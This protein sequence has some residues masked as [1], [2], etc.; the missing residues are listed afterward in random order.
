AAN[1]V[2]LVIH[3]HGGQHSQLR[4]RK[5]K[6]GRCTSDDAIAVIRSMAVRWS[7][8]DIAATLNRMGMRTSDLK[9][10]TVKRV[11]TARRKRGILGCRSVDPNGEWFTMSEA[12][13]HI[14]VTND[15][16][17]RLIKDG[18]LRAKQAVPNAPWRIQAC[19]L[20]SEAVTVELTRKHRPCGDNCKT[21]L[22]MFSDT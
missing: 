15:M 5:P 13:K 2:V 7:D 18:I 9:T 1:E 21:Q 3:W 22:S 8:Q 4:V 16:I 19:D 11:L 14:G 20:H 17:R 12:A 6:S 10:W